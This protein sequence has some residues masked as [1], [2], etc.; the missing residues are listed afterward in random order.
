MKTRKVISAILA[1]ACA[2]SAM[3]FSATAA[4][5]GD[6]TLTAAGATTFKISSTVV[7]P[8]ISVSIPSSVSAVINPYGVA[9]S[10]K[11]GSYG[12]EGVTSPIYKIRNFTTTSGVAVQVTPSLTTST[13]KN[14][15]DSTKLDPTFDV[16]A[17]GTITNAT[18]DKS[19]AVWVEAIKG[20]EL[21]YVAKDAKETSDDKEFTAFND[22]A[23]KTAVETSANWTTTNKAGTAPFK[24][25]T[26]T[27]KSKDATAP[28]LEPADSVEITAL[29]AATAYVAADAGA[30]PPVTE[31]KSKY[32]FAA[33]RI[34]GESTPM[35]VDG[36]WTTSDK[37]TLNLVLNI[38]PTDYAAFYA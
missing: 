26:V 6:K 29:P 12:A 20:S 1:G 17:K 28:K 30:T 24:D 27:D 9:V 32:G 37:L 11:N 15:S 8:T 3:S 7:T 25:L 36:G 5:A 10:D 33:F 18:E 13:T 38:Y 19:L 14:A 23:E 31:V 4:T 2:L 21:A 16:V 22:A 34:N 35:S